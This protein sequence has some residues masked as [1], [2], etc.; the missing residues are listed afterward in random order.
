MASERKTILVVDDESDT[1]EFVE[2]IISEMSGFSVI[3]AQDGESGLEQAEAEQPD[4]VILDVL[5]PKRTGF[6]VFNA[7]RSN[8][9]TAHIP[10]IMLTGVSE[11]MGMKYSKED[12]GEFYGKEPEDFID[13]PI[14]PERLQEA[15]RSVLDV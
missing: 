12:M 2:T 9:Q 6:E 8:P 13:K 15:I 14:D 7:L 1:L 10:A 4:L 3:T 5:M 11:K